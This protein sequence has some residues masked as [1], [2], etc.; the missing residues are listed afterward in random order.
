MNK[1]WDLTNSNDMQFVSGHSIEK[2]TS[3]DDVFWRYSVLMVV[4]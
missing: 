1:I 2:K 4:Q 3:I